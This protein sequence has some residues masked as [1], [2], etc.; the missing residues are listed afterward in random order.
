MKKQDKQPL[1]DSVKIIYE[2]MSTDINN[3]QSLICGN[4]L[5]TSSTF[6][7]KENQN[8][9]LHLKKELSLIKRQLEDLE[10][11]KR[12]AIEITKNVILNRD[13]AKNDQMKARNANSGNIEINV[14]ESTTSAGSETV[15]LCCESSQ[16]SKTDAE[17]FKKDELIKTLKETNKNLYKTL[18][19]QEEKHAELTKSLQSS[20]AQ[21]R[22]NRKSFQKYETLLQENISL[23]ATITELEEK[24]RSKE[25]TNKKIVQAAEELSKDIK[26]RD[27]LNKQLN[28]SV[29][30]C[31]GTIIELGEMNKKLIESNSKL[32]ESIKNKEEKY[33]NLRKKYESV[34]SK[35]DTFKSKLEKSFLVNYLLK[36][37]Y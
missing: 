2:D 9:T 20:Q 21:L 18:K 30:K 19:E 11:S 36:F 22:E 14:Q 37:Y 15:Q 35:I 8:S 13:E 28:N 25:E 6:T 27:E 10:D 29:D 34:E 7:N 33:W 32:T 23:S 12:N 31:K 24:L 3:Q 16:I 26:D 4:V 1:S 5:F 17:L